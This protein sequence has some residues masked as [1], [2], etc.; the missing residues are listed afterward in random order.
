[1]AGLA[2]GAWGADPP[3]ALRQ[4]FGRS[5]RHVPSEWGTPPARPAAFAL[6]GLA[7]SGV[8]A[9]ALSHISPSRPVFI[10]VLALVGAG[11]GL[12]LALVSRAGEGEHA[13]TPLYCADLAGGALGA[14]LGTLLL[15]PAFGL[16]VTATLC[17]LTALLAGLALAFGGRAR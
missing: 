13:F 2:V 8:A 17:A 1:M 4:A 6:S 9:A 14:W 5:L 16:A 11:V 7:L 10:I 12:T 3:A 15:I